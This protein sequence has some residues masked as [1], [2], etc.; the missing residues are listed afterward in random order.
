MK[1][2]LSNK[3]N[4]A[5]STIPI[6][7]DE[8]FY[9]KKLLKEHPRYQKYEGIDVNA[10]RYVRVYVRSVIF[11]LIKTKQKFHFSTK[12]RADVK[13]KIGPALLWEGT[14]K[15]DSSIFCV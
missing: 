4:L 3:V 15:Q 6:T 11:F 10:Y 14:L 9:L 2:T 7:L 12:V 8:R 1:A 5:H 13:K